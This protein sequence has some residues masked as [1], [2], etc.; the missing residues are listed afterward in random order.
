ML[1]SL[2]WLRRYH[3]PDDDSLSPGHLAH[4]L[5]MAGFPVVAAEDID[6][7]LRL[8]VEITSNRPDLQC[9]LGVAL[10]VAAIF[11]GTVSM[12]DARLPAISGDTIDVAVEA[13][14]LCPLYT[15]RIVRGVKVGPSPAWLRRAL[16]SVGQRTVNN[17][18][19]VT[20]FVLLECGHPLHAFDVS[21]L[22]GPRLVARRATGESL[23]ALDGSVLELHGDDC[24]IA[25]AEAPVALGGVMG[26]LR[27]EVDEGTIDVALE[28][29]VFAPLA[30]RAA[31]RRHQLHTESSFRFERFVDAARA[32]WASDR[33][34]ALLVECCGATAV[35]P[36]RAAGPRARGGEPSASRITLR[37]AQLERVLGTPVDTADI[38]RVLAG[39]GLAQ[40]DAADGYTTWSIPSWRPD[41]VEEIDLLEEVARIVGFDRIPDV[42]RIPVRPQIVDERVRAATRLRGALVAVGLRECCTEPFVGE[43]AH[44]IALLD[45]RPALRVENP[46]RADEAL[47]RRS[48][49]GPL[50]R[51]VRG[52]QDRGVAAVRFF[53]TAPVYMR[54]E[55]GDDVR[56]W[57][58]CGIA[59][60]GAYDDVK[61]AV[62]AAL[63]ALGLR[64]AVTFARGA[65]SPLDRGHSATLR[66]GDEVVGHIGELG[67][68]ARR[69]FGFECAIAVAELRADVLLGRAELDRPYRKISRFPAV[70]R[71]LAIVLRDDVL[72]EEVDRVV[73]AAAGDLLTD[74]MPFD[75]FRS[76][77]I[78]AG[79]KSLALRM[80]LRSPD[81]TLTGEQADACVARILAALAAEIGGELRS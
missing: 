73:R 62:D 27:S 39:L 64:H 53:A 2:E 69:A 48:V 61:G 78:G 8:D 54:A 13:P 52:N 47:L 81:R 71:D 65:P 36:I 32:Q 25:D 20:N 41:L 60:T 59:L 3:R 37:T 77:Q 21:K 38:E 18:V 74:L 55:D 66:M 58:L 10:E 30:I 14:D 7:D 26:G 9:H 75:V 72:W 51:V 29:A 45:D 76:A 43:G 11:G 79:R 31:S 12:P 42:V 5:T 34:A 50:L 70:V 19:D 44:D 80:E 33:A 24:V 49:L 68:D 15:A 1:I 23:T 35:G 28:C 40:C 46:M 22:R 67:K 6:G 63:A 17:V 16:E 4:A 57:L 56:E